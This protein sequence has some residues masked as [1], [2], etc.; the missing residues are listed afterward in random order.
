[1]IARRLFIAVNGMYHNLHVKHQTA[2]SLSRAV[3]Y[4]IDSTVEA[5][6]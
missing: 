3:T 6:K 5:R 4:N 1:M 2:H